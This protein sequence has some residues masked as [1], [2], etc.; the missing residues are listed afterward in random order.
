MRHLADH[1][2][3]NLRLFLLY[4]VLRDK[5]PLTTLTTNQLQQYPILKLSVPYTR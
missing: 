5:K 3:G 2:I 4:L 1:Y